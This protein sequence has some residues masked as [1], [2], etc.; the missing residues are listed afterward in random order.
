MFLSTMMFEDPSFCGIFCAVP[1]SLTI[2]C[3]AVFPTQHLFKIQCSN[4]QCQTPMQLFQCNNVWNPHVLLC[5]QCDDSEVCSVQPF[6]GQSPFKNPDGWFHVVRSAPDAVP[7][8]QG[9]H[10]ATKRTYWKHPMHRNSQVGRFMALCLGHSTATL[11]WCWLNRSHCSLSQS[12]TGT[13]QQFVNVF[14]L[15]FWDHGFKDR[16]AKQEA[17][18]RTLEVNLELGTKHLGSSGCHI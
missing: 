18:G 14:S 16:E 8:A 13:A 1:Q 2:P 7:R 11:W 10:V 15:H 5:V 6:F 3:F 17:S 12:K 4:S 9:P